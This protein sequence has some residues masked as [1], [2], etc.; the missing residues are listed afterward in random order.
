FTLS[1]WRVPIDGGEETKVLDSVHPQT[2]WTVRQEGIYYLSAP[3]ANGASDLCLFEFVSGKIKKLLRAPQKM[4]ESGDVAISPDGRTVLYS[5][6]D[7]AGSDLMLVEN[8]Q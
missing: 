3:D 6:A 8:F 4:T 2:R 7:E 1:V 5:Q